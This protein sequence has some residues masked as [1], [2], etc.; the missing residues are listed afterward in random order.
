MKVIQEGTSSAC[1]TPSAGAKPPTTLVYGARPI[2]STKK[3]PLSQGSSPLPR[4]QDAESGTPAPRAEP[5]AVPPDPTLPAGPRAA[6][7]K[8][9][10]KPRNLLALLASGP[11]TAL[12]HRNF[13][14]FYIGQLVSLIGT[15]IHAT[16]QG[17]LVL[18][19]TDSEFML[20]A[21]QAV[22]SLPVLVFTLYAGALADQADKRR[23]LVI[24]QAVALLPA[25]AMALLTDFGHI[26]IGWILLFA[27]MLGSS[28]AFEIPVRQSFFV[29][30]VG[31]EDLTGAIALNSSAF[32]ATRIVGPAIAGILIGTLGI[33]ACF[34]INAVSYLAVVAGLLL[35]RLPRFQ[36]PARRPPTGEQ[37]KEGFHWLWSH[38]LART[39]IALIASASLFAFPYLVL[40]PVFARDILDVGAQGLG[41]MLSASGAGA[42]AGGLTLAA[43][44][45]RVRRGRL[46][47]GAMLM[48]VACVAGFAVSR[49]LPL[50]L[51]L[52]AGAGFATILNTATVNGLLQSLV[53]DALRGRVM[54]VYV[55]MFLGMMPAGSIWGGAVAGAFGAPVAVVLGAAVMLVVALGVW[56]R[57]AEL[58]EVR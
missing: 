35:I 24:A 47:F 7:R 44:S 34:Y 30:L 45:R 6:E 53:P 25:L 41:W 11:F 15:W 18:E 36:P 54:G 49:S 57:V 40:L 51:M 39:L 3:A 26:T 56:W 2:A 42:L 22:M 58:R 21:V 31:K 29:D 12:R 55:F 37:L 13:R 43:I 1:S 28:N 16:A 32:N 4:P 48:F 27:L 38:R 23:I 14:L 5:F 50:S 19:L 20:G 33:A 9:G 46:L 17:W 52:L 10:G 8:L